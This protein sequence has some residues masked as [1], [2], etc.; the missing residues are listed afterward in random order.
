MPSLTVDDLTTQTYEF[1]EDR[2]RRN[3]R[4]VA[5]EARLVLEASGD[6]KKILDQI[7]EARMGQPRP[8]TAAEID[9]WLQQT[10]NRDS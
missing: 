1:L 10:R 9:G 5:D 3:G 8:A 7:A 4:S 6:R 2:A